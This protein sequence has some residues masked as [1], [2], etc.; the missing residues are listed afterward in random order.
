VAPAKRSLEQTGEETAISSSSK[1]QKPN[2]A[3]KLYEKFV[4][5]R[6]VATKP[7][8]RI[9]SEI[10]SVQG[11]KKTPPTVSGNHSV[12]LLNCY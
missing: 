8:E 11:L 2:G 6:E 10:K 12:V 5:G 3:D 7:L 1:K 9:A 4:N